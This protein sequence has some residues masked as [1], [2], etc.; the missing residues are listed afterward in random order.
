MAVIH[1]III[2]MQKFSPVV[3]AFLFNPEGDILLVKHKPHLPWALPGGHVENDET[4]HDAMLR[5][6]AEEFGIRARFFTVDQD[7]ILSHRGK[8]LHHLP[9]PL[10]IYELAYQDDS[11][12]D[13]SRTEYIFLMETDDVITRAQESEIAQYA[14]FSP[15]KILTMKPNTETWDF[16]IQMLEKLIGEENLED[17]S[18]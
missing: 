16:Y 3:R 2:S 6:I 1:V 9:L 17:D 14:W 10:S 18:F 12:K 11:G 13:K 8:P 7:E 4:I 15:E 5:E